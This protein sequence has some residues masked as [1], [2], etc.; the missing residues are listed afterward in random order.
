MSSAPQDPNFLILKQDQESSRIGS[1][2][3]SGF[4][5]AREKDMNG[6][7]KFFDKRMD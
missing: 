4:G 2:Y 1:D 7:L 6:D 3:L 5:T